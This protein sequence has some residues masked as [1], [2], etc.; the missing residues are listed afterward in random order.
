[1][2]PIGIRA[3]VAGYDTILG[4]QVYSLDPEGSFVG[5][6]AVCLGKGSTQIMSA[7]RSR[8]VGKHPLS[9]ED[10]CDLIHSCLKACLPSVND[11]DSLKIVPGDF[12]AWKLEVGGAASV[13]V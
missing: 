5:W 8:V 2:R 13:C 4:Y 11:K 1:M 12:D 10:G 6:K 7:L 9:A 3:I